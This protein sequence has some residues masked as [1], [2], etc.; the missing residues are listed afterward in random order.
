MAS[1]M[2]FP[3]LPKPMLSHLLVYLLRAIYPLIS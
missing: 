3:P 2:A 1:A